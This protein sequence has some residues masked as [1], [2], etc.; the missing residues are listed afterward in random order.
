[1]WSILSYIG[2]WTAFTLLE[3]PASGFLLFLLSPM[4]I[5]LIDL[6]GDPIAVDDQLWLWQDKGHYSGIPAMNYVGWYITAGVISTPL[7]VMIM[8]TDPGM[9][10][11]WILYTPTMGYVFYFLILTKIC[12]EKRLVLARNTGIVIVALLIIWLSFRFSSLI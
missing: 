1:M 2:V 6:L 9:I 4:L 12:F 8:A 5:T 11:S 10:P 7:I 3:D